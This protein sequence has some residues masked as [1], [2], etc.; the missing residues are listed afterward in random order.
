ME[1][2]IG[3]PSYD[4]RLLS[5]SNT[6][7]DPNNSTCYWATELVTDKDASALPLFLYFIVAFA[8]IR[9][10]KILVDMR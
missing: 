6:Q 8:L 7:G 4:L 9:A 2:N 3:V 10:F 5:S 1:S